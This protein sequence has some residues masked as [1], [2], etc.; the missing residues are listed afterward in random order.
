MFCES[1][2]WKIK[3]LISIQG[4]RPNCLC[5]LI[6]LVKK[7]CP[8]IMTIFLLHSFCQGIKLL[9]VITVWNVY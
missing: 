8:E 6:S 1:F 4:G 3:I 2:I 9:F 5:S 7:F